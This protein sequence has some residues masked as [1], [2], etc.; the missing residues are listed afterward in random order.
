MC[1]G[2]FPEKILLFFWILSKL[3][4]PPQQQESTNDDLR[5]YHV[6]VSKFGRG[7]KVIWTKSKRTA[8]FSRE[9]VPYSRALKNRWIITEP[10]KSRNDKMIIGKRIL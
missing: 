2:R 7:G 8:V 4:P 1:E 6:K 5:R 9:T 10:T 3:P